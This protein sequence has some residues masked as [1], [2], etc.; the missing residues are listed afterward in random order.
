LL[1]AGTVRFLIEFVRV[2][3]PIART[4]HTGAA[5]RGRDRLRWRGRPR[6]GANDVRAWSGRRDACLELQ[7]HAVDPAANRQGRFQQSASCA[8]G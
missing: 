2:N 7:R 3:L 4:V 6:K 5:H 1:M 8:P